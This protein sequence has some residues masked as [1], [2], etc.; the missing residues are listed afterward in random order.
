MLTGSEDVQG[1]NDKDKRC[2]ND[3]VDDDRDGLDTSDNSDNALARNCRNHS[4]ATSFRP[5]GLRLFREC[6]RLR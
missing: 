2:D 3:R 1:N 4:E 6:Q 5:K